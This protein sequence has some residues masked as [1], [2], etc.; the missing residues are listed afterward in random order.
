MNDSCC[1]DAVRTLGDAAPHPDVDS[2]PAAAAPEHT[3]VGA[4]ACRE[5]TRLGLLPP[6][7]QRLAGGATLVHENAPARCFHMVLAGDF[8]LVKTAADGYE[9]V[10]DFAGSFDVLGFDGLSSG[11]Y[12]ASAVALQDASVY[13]MAVADV[14]RL[15]RGSLLFDREW[16]RSLGRQVAR[17]GE[18]ALLMAAVSAERRVAR[19]LLQLSRRMEARGQSPRRLRLR[20]SRREIASYLGLAHESISRALTAL[21]GAGLVRV[22]QRDLE[23]V[24]DTGLAS[25]AQCTRGASASCAPAAM[26]VR[27]TPLPRVVP[28]LP[29]GNGFVFAQG[30]RGHL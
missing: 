2:T 17:L 22:D 14:E 13:T 5:T 18:L 30:M 11:H 9:Q 10:L 16:Q 15:R 20:M 1:T 28:R 6:R 21:D 24:D 8:K 4:L 26:P 7:L 12:G 29:P 19:F 23:I 27:Q 3:W 25:F